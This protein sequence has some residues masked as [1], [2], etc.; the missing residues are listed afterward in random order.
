MGR[1]LQKVVRER[2]FFWKLE[3]FKQTS[4]MPPKRFARDVR[5]D[6]S[7]DEDN[8]FSGSEDS[9]ISDSSS[10]S[11]SSSTSSS[12]EERKRRKKKNAKKSK[13]AKK[14]ARHSDN[15]ESEDDPDPY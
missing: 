10:S 13:K 9:P 5:P 3:N 11:S 7:S 14:R 15:S 4:T 8:P 2:S 12:E 6:K 1:L